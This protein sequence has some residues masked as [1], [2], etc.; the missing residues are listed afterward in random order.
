MHVLVV[1]VHRNWFR[2]AT[3]AEIFSRYRPRSRCLVY[4]GALREGHNAVGSC[5]KW[6]FFGR[7]PGRSIALVI[8]CRLHSR[9]P[10][11]AH[12]RVPQDSSE[13]MSSE[14]VQTARCLL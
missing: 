3:L 2:C 11:D 1:S 12:A 13:Y 7:L 4:S 9:S 5:R 8:W 6:I 14:L 10:G